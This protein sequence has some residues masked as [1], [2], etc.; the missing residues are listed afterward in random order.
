MKRKKK[1][2]REKKIKG[3]FGHFTSSLPSKELGEAV[4]P[5][6]FVQNKLE[7]EKV[8]FPYEPELK[9][10]FHESHAKRALNLI[11]SYE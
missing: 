8:A 7:P 3:Y 2:K 10:F 11:V 4:L 1:K 6:I 9:L 5:N